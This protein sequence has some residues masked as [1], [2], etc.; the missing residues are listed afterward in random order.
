[1]L[2]RQ[3]TEQDFTAIYDLV[4]AAFQTARV[5]DGDEQDFV[6]Q[7][8]S[9]SSYIPELALVME[10]DGRLIGHIMLTKTYVQGASGSFEALLLAP[11]AIALEHREKSNGSKLIAESFQRAKTMGYTAVFLVGDP[12]F[13]ER[14]GFRP[15]V[16]FGIQ[17]TLPI[18]EQ[19]VMACELT[20]NALNGVS[21][22]V[23]IV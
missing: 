23:D 12:A 9:G 16:S 13:Y 6:V 11:I 22:T 1:M 21:G 15:T 19:N 7:L 8:R 4:K 18:P 20:P 14:F 17:Y 10:Q 2:I 3:E 5:S